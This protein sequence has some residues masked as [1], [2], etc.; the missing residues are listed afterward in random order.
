MEKEE[1]L[2]KRVLRRIKVANP[3]KAVHKEF[4]QQCRAFGEV[5]VALLSAH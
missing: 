3:D 5:S 2:E 1:S 4:T